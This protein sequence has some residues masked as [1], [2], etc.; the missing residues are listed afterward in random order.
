M[1][2]K[3]LISWLIAIWASYVFLESLPYKFTG[4]AEPIHI[5]SVIGAWISSFLGNTIGALFANYGAYLVGSFELLT[6][7]V[8]LSPIVLKNKRQR[9]HFIG[10]IMAT[11][12]MS[13]AVFFHLITPLGW[14]V[15]WTENGQTYRDAD[16]ANAALSIIILG[17]V[18]T[19]INKK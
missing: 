12:V 13:G 10:G 14:I 17:L 2:S 4:A 7:L 19:Y 3:T 8:L 6:S 11:T 15:E 5:F 16:L 9:I 1:K 18:L